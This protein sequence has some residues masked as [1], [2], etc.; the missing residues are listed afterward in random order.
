[1][2]QL[3]E[4]L[5]YNQIKRKRLMDR[6]K[7]VFVEIYPL[8]ALM[9][10]AEDKDFAGTMVVTD[11]DDGDRPSV[12]AYLYIPI[13]LKKD[14]PPLEDVRKGDRVGMIGVIISTNYKGTGKGENRV[15][16]AI[17]MSYGRFGHIDEK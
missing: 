14:S 10:I 12:V 3:W 5:T 6:D 9:V 11:V 17:H 16:N 4:D 13:E 2:K 8:M 1:L 15:A 7:P